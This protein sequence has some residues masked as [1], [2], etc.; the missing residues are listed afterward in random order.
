[1]NRIRR[2][3]IIFLIVIAI[4]GIIHFTTDKTPKESA[5][6]KAIEVAPPVDG[7]E[8]R[9]ATPDAA[10]TKKILTVYCFPDS[11]KR[12]ESLVREAVEHDFAMEFK[13]GSV[14]VKV[15]DTDSAEK[16]RLMQEFKPVPP[17]VVLAVSINGKTTDWINLD[18]VRELG[19]NKNA[20]LNYIRDNI[21]D[22]IGKNVK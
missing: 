19:S 14:M 11:G 12:W 4:A 7:P 6:I 16:D 13:N 22:F 18:Q 9:A 15:I 20:F 3:V 2:M 10:Q 1:M 17:A 21:R 5:A 8:L